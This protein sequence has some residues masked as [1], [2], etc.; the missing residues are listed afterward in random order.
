MNNILITGISGGLGRGLASKLLTDTSTTIIGTYNA[1]NENIFELAAKYP[2]RLRLQQCDLLQVNDFHAWISALVSTYGPLGGFVHCAGF[3]R[4][5][6]INMTKPKDLEE[7]WKIHAQVPMLIISA[8]SKRKNHSDRASIVL[9]SSQAAHEGAAG[10]TAYAAAK[11]ALEG[12]L[13]PAAAELMAKNIRINILCLGLINTTM[14]QKWLE[15]L[16]TEQQQIL[17]NSYP[18]GL[19]QVEDANGI[20]SFLLSEDSRFINGQIVTADGGHSARKI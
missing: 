17:T 20:I 11:G 6:P 19:G 5:F 13:A 14:S 2:D 8:F 16:T 3:D 18:L 12:Y 7:L 10:H 9:I 1:G 4:L 15:K